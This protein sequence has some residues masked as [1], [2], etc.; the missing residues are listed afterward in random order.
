MI[1]CLDDI[2]MP[3]KLFYRSTDLI[4]SENLEKGN[5]KSRVVFYRPYTTEKKYYVPL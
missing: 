2:K 3:C 4:T 5:K 1:I